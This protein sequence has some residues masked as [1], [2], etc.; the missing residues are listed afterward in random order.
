MN[1]YGKILLVD[2]DK[3]VLFTARTLL[4]NEFAEVVTLDSPGNLGDL[5][6][7]ED[8]DIIVLDMNFTA[9]NVSGKEGLELLRKI[10]KIKPDSY[11]VMST[12]Y[13]DIDLA[14]ESMKAGAVDFIVK[15]WQRERLLATLKNV[16]DLR[17]AR[18]EIDLLYSKQRILKGDIEKDFSEIISASP[19]MKAIFLTVSKVAATDASVLILGENGTGKE[20]IAREIH[21][22]SHR[23]GH[24]FVPIDMGALT[25]SL[26]ESELFGHER[27]AFTD[28]RDQRIG[29]FEMASGGTVFLDEIGNLSRDLQSKLLSVLQN[30][31][32]IRVGSNKTIPVDFRLICATNRPLLDL[33]SGN[34]FREDLLY[35]INT[36]VINLPPLR[37]RKEDIPLLVTHFLKIYQNK[38]N[39]IDC[40]LGKETIKS[41]KKYSWPGNIR[42]LQHATERAVIL[43]DGSTLRPNDFNLQLTKNEP[44]S[45]LLFSS[46]RDIEKEAIINAIASCDGNLTKVADKLRLGRSTLYRKMKKYGLQ[47]I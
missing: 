34:G 2:D 43:S 20:L 9:G 6:R 28:A 37:E 1:K 42:E 15:P 23:S 24:D 26:F 30:K 17:N 19:L 35:R 7:N 31:Q 36:V 41:L 44:S 27:G 40:T 14:V 12:A 3:D 10:L 22:Q 4:K 33:I 5:V 25:S 29:R 46:I 13:G 11:I 38:Y 39:R 8:F 45:A 16:S 18:K 21:R 47:Q 32:I